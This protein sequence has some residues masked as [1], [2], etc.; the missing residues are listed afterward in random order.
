MIKRRNLL[1]TVKK[2]EGKCPMREGDKMFL[3]RGFIDSK[4]SDNFCCFALGS[5]FPLIEP[6]A[7]HNPKELG[8]GKKEDSIVFRCPDTAE[9]G[10]G[11]A[12]FE[13]SYL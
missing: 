5:L 4:K 12:W 3:D 10:N 1:I 11:C 8:W 9:Y 7:M 6:L 13:I 2:V